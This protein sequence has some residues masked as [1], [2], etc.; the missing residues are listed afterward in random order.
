MNNTKEFYKFY[1]DK[2]NAIKYEPNVTHYKL[3]EWEKEGKLKAVVTQNIDG[4]HQKAG[5]KNVFELHGSIYRNYC[6][7]CHK[8]YGPEIIFGEDTAEI[9]TCSECGGLIKPD[10]V[11]Y[12][13]GL[14]DEVVTGAINAI[15]NADTLIVAGTSLTVYPASGLIRYF[16]GNNLI[17]VNR[18][19]TSYDNMASVVI[20]ESVGKVFGVN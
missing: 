10:V 17:L 1:K 6:T 4:L 7:K 16:R 2:L 8:F 19:S 15:A 12:E 9:P 13:E 3:A 14:D 5:S 20:N 11:L 18:D